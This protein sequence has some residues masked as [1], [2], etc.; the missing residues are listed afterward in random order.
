MPESDEVLQ[1]NID[2][3]LRDMVDRGLVESRIEN[4]EEI[5][6]LTEAGKKFADQAAEQKCNEYELSWS[7]RFPAEDDASA[8]QYAAPLVKQAVESAG[9]K[10]RLRR[11]YDDRQPKNI[12]L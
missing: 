2:E 11:L 5:Y 4:G 7:V 12:A 6:S 10:V 9:V 1:A 3:T 8:R